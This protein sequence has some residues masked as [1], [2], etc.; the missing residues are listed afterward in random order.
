MLLSGS[1]DGYFIPD[2]PKIIGSK[3]TF[4]RG[5]GI[6]EYSNFSLMREMKEF[7]T[8]ST[9]LILLIIE[10]IYQYVLEDENIKQRMKVFFEF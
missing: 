7:S 3:V 1:P 9:A 2:D 10:K 4:N 6:P 8:N 5:K